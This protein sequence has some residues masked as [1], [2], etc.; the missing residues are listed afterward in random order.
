MT[1]MHYA[2]SGTLPMTKTCQSL[3]CLTSSASLCDYRSSLPVR[4][5]PCDGDA[6]LT[7][8]TALCLQHGEPLQLSGI[9]HVVEHAGRLP[10]Y[11]GRSAAARHSQDC[12]LI[13]SLVPAAAA[14]ASSNECTH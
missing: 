11:L 4:T 9:P 8:K 2:T 10:L 12:P 6:K 3:F 7:L 1:R 14:P 5:H 13:T